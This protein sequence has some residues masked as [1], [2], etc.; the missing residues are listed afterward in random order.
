MYK[1]IDFSLFPFSFLP[2]SFLFLPA[3]CCPSL[4]C[5]PVFLAPLPSCEACSLVVSRLVFFLSRHVFS[6]LLLSSRTPK[7]AHLGAAHLTVLWTIPFFGVKKI[8]WK[9]HQKSRKPIGTRIP[10]GNQ[11]ASLSRADLS[12]L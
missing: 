5:L 2:A 12:L 7:K 10:G 1:E 4:A 11:K 8:F 6:C 3:L 9:K